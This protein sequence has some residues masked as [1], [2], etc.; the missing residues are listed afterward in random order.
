MQNIFSLKYQSCDQRKASCGLSCVF[1]RRW[2]T[3]VEFK[4]WYLCQAPVEQAIGSSGETTWCVFYQ[5][6]W[7]RFPQPLLVCFVKSKAPQWR[8][9]SL[10][11][12]ALFLFDVL[13]ITLYIVLR[14]SAGSTA[15]YFLWENFFRR[16]FASSWSKYVTLRNLAKATFYCLLSVIFV[17]QGKAVHCLR[18]WLN[19]RLS[20]DASGTAVPCRISRVCSQSIL[21][22]SRGSTLPV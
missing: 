10:E 13:A 3:L 11:L 16:T 12:S 14:N 8:T 5:I 9:C 18:M 6:L 21:V 22:V 4:A 1:C 20:G 15:L 19:N 17:Y 2:S 7:N